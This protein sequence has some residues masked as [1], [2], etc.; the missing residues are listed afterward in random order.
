MVQ[1]H[2]ADIIGIGFSSGIA[3]I[4]DIRADERILHVK[5]DE[6]PISAIAFRTDGQEILATSNTTGNIALWDLSQKGRLLYIIRGAHDGPV[7]AIQWIPNQPVLVS[8]GGDN[9]VKVAYF[10]LQ[11]CGFF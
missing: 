4:H 10:N 11:R 7:T 8:S 9:S 6:E 1:S 5:M 3:T 2:V